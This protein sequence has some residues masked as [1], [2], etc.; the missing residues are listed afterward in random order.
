LEGKNRDNQDVVSTLN[1]L[2]EI[3]KDGEEGFKTC[4]EDAENPKLKAFFSDRSQD[5]RT[6]AAELQ[7]LVR[8]L[9][10]QPETKSSLSATL[11]RNWIDLKTAITSNDD[12]AVLNECERGE[13]IALGSYRKAL[14][15]DLPQNVRSVLERQ[16]QGVQR[17]HDQVKQLRDAAR[18]QS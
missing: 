7:A 16:L 2:G 15:K 13:D 9:G 1:D 17:N 6:G 11:H 18:V 10:E 4:A 8:A 3:S 12:V 5:C 14:Q